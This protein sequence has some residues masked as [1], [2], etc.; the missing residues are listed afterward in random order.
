MEEDNQKSKF[1]SFISPATIIKNPEY[2][3]I[4]H[5]PSQIVER[6]ETFDFYRELA[7]FMK[8]KKPNN[9]LLKG[10]PGSGKTVT[11][12]FVLKEISD[13]KDNITSVI[14]NCNAKSPL[15][16]MKTLIMQFN[17][18]QPIGNF[19]TLS[20]QFFKSLDKDILIVLDEI[21]RSVKIEKLLFNLS[22]PTEVVSDFKHNISIVI[23]SN[24]LHWE[25]NLKDYI[26]SSLQLKQITF[27]P[28]S[29]NEIK[30]ILKVRIRRGFID[31]NAIDKSFIDSIAQIC[32][33]RRRGDCR[34]A[35]EAVFYAAQN[36]E[37]NKRSNIIEEDIKK[38]LKL[39]I[40]Q[41]D[42]MLVQKLRDNQLLILYVLCSHQK[43]NL[44]EIHENYMNILK[45]DKLKIEPITKIMVFHII[46][47]LDDLCL[48]DKKIV[49]SL[50]DKKI[51]RRNMNI[52][53]N[54]NQGTV[55]DELSVRD[56]RL[57]NEKQ[58]ED[59]DEK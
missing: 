40:D 34:V 32:V 43:E 52:T 59:Q 17:K 24:N 54:V 18:T 6:K 8:Y 3:K 49:V 48:I 2:F 20:K 56:L 4:T 1:R 7:T 25:D 9:I 53:C 29:E 50:D 10:Y 12:N 23:I 13:V 36:A 57:S 5:T 45:S 27:N 47:Y 26:R 44:E 19:T 31:E 39:A 33:K 11:V 22:R 35:I 21:D 14:V 58:K 51:P 30:K 16:V 38:A 46:N 42:K 37:A 41:S 55:I 15:E 28:Y